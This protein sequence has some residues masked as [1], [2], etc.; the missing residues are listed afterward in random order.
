MSEEA[1]IFESDGYMKRAHKAKITGPDGLTTEDHRADMDEL[2]HMLSQA[3]R[4]GKLLW[5]DYYST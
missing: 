2:I 5:V 4:A 3:N 1:S